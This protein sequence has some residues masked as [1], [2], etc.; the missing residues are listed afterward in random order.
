MLQ[1]KVV[2]F[3]LLLIFIFVTFLTSYRIAKRFSEDFYV[4]YYSYQIVAE[5]ILEGK[6]PY[7][8]NNYHITDRQWPEPPISFYPSAI[9]FYPFSLLGDS[10][11]LVFLSFSIIVL[12]A[13]SGYLYKIFKNVLPGRWIQNPCFC[14]AVFIYLINTFPVQT[15]LRNGQISLIYSGLILLLLYFDNIGVRALAIALLFLFKASTGWIF[16]LAAAVC[17]P[18]VFFVSSI[19]IVLGM[20]LPYL[21]GGDVFNILIS[22]D[23]LLKYS[24]SAGMNQFQD[25][26]GGGHNII[27]LNF[28]KLEVLRKSLTIVLS[29]FLAR[30][31]FK[32]RCPTKKV[33]P[34]LIIYMSSMLF[35]YHRSYDLSFAVLFIPY[36]LGGAY[37][38]REYTVTAIYALFGL[39]FILPMRVVFWLEA[40]IGEVIGENSMFYISSVNHPPFVL[41]SR[42]FPLQA[43][44]TLL[45]TS[46]LFYVYFM[47]KNHFSNQHNIYIK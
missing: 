30:V 2:K 47:K 24:L 9:L 34:L 12:I 26:S 11:V 46:F 17:S 3:F 33:I 16:V 37:R 35:V 14:I 28:I 20:L 4:D 5:S 36:L 23:K 19:F 32:V 38:D 21:F 27:N 7:D 22:Y 29:L 43:L 45:L 39:F 10:G 25:F 41:Y 18:I 6:D 44:V 42:I 15:V 1:S 40:Q 8:V 31:I 13:S